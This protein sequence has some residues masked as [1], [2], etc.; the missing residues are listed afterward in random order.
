[1]VAK[2]TNGLPRQ[3]IAMWENR[4]YSIRFHL[5][6]P[7]RYGVLHC[8]AVQI[9]RHG[10]VKRVEAHE[11]WRAVLSKIAAVKSAPPAWVRA[12]AVAR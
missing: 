6:V 2:F 12:A 7:L 5:P 9:S 3:F 10:R 1:M 4:R 11:K 8:S